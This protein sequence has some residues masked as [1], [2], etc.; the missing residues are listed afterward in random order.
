[1]IQDIAPHH[2]D[3]AYRPLPPSAGSCAL[4]Y[5][6][7]TVLV[8]RQGSA[9]EYPR[10]QDLESMNPDIYDHYTYLFSIDG[11]GYYLL[12]HV[13]APTPSRFSM[14]NTEM[15][16]SAVPRHLAFAGITG[17]QLYGWYRDHR[18]CGRCGGVLK[19]DEKERM[20]RC[21]GCHT[22]EYPKISPAVIIGVTDGSRLLLSKYAGR[23]YK[24][25]A[26]LAGF[27]EIGETIEE[28]VK[29]EVMEEVGLKVTN[30]RYYGSQPWS[31]SGTVL[32]GFFCD[33]ASPDEITLD[34]EELAL[35]EWFEREDIPMDD[36]RISLTWE[37][38]RHFK[39]GACL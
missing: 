13:S 6:E 39:E 30:I 20:L 29:R 27:V 8:S 10:F 3:N 22:M 32:M 37:M 1:M 14:E 33:L 31:F 11:Q 9:I 19:K 23:T 21:D 17:F 4:Y 28:T 7:H 26:L 38:I 5:E 12:E 15:F 34:Q 2:Y 25:Y 35:A 36:S 16:R 24:K 18:Y